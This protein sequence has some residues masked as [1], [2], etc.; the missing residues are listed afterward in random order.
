MNTLK[1]DK[2]I[3]CH[4]VELDAIELVVKLDKSIS[5]LSFT[6]MRQC[7]LQKG[8]GMFFSDVVLE[9]STSVVRAIVNLYVRENQHFEVF[10]IFNGELE[11]LTG[12]KY[13]IDCSALHRPPVQ[14][15]P[16]VNCKSK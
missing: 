5:L 6:A 14:R 7:L 13:C 12:D 4:Y 10:A 11:G 16:S 3:L 2:T 1:V 9:P 8:D 15:K